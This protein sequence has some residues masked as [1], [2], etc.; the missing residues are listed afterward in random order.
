MAL[1]AQA[2][3]WG[4]QA[5]TETEVDLEQTALVEIRDREA[6]VEEEDV[7]FLVLF[8]SFGVT[9]LPRWSEATVG[10]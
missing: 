1:A 5:V 7:L 2:R 9:V 8:A 10:L 3:S 6:C 4:R